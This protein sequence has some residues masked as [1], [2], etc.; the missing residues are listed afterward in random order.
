MLICAEDLGDV[1]W[2]A[3]ID[4][5]LVMVIIQVGCTKCFSL[6][7]HLDVFIVLPEGANELFIA[8]FFK[9]QSLNH[10]MQEKT[11]YAC[12]VAPQYGGCG[13]LGRSRTGQGI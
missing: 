11:E 7:I 9:T 4:R 1:P 3:Q 6:P 5:A 10:Q 12:V 8:F 2:H 13:I